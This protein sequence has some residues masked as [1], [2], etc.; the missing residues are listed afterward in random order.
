MDTKGKFRSKL[1]ARGKRVLG[2]VLALAMLATM[3]VVSQVGTRAVT[4]TYMSTTAAPTITF[5]APEAAWLAM[6]GATTGT[7]NSIQYWASISGGTGVSATGALTFSVSGATLTSCTITNDKIAGSWSNT[8]LSLGSGLAVPAQTHNTSVLSEWKA[9]FKLQGSNQTYIAYAYTVLWCPSLLIAATAADVQTWAAGPSTTYAACGAFGML[10]LH[11]VGTGSQASGGHGTH[12]NRYPT[13]SFRDAL[14]N[15]AVAFNNTPVDPLYVKTG[16]DTLNPVNSVSYVSD[17]QTSAGHAG[18]ARPSNTNATNKTTVDTSRFSNL[19]AVPGMR[20]A[21]VITSDRASTSGGS[22]NFTLGSS[23]DSGTSEADEFKWHSATGPNVTFTTGLGN[24]TVNGSAYYQNKLALSTNDIICALS[25]NVMKVNKNTVLRPAVRAGYTDVYAKDWIDNNDGTSGFQQSMQKVAMWLGDPKDDNYDTGFNYAG[26]TT[27]TQ[28][29]NNHSAEVRLLLQ[30]SE[31][32]LMSTQPGTP[33]GLVDEDSIYFK[34][35]ESIH[36]GAPT[37]P[38]Y[39]LVAVDTNTSRGATVT[40]HTYVQDYKYATLDEPYWDFY[41][42]PIVKYNINYVFDSMTNENALVTGTKPGPDN[43]CTEQ[44]PPT[45]AMFPLGGASTFQLPGYTFAGWQCT[46]K[47]GTMTVP[48]G[49]S[50]AYFLTHNASAFGGDDFPPAT[51]TTNAVITMHAMWTKVD[52]YRVN[53][54]NTT[55]PANTVTSTYQVSA[56]AYAV[57]DTV[58]LGDLP[59][60]FTAAGYTQTGW[61]KSAGG[62]ALGSLTFPANPTAGYS[63]DT[64]GSL[65]LFPVWQTAT[66]TV[67]FMK[68]DNTTVFATSTP[69]YS[70]GA[71]YGTLPELPQTEKPGYHFLGWNTAANAT[72][73]NIT[74]TTVVGTVAGTV[75]L[76][77]AWAPWEFTVQYNLNGGGGT[78]PAPFSVVYDSTTPTA[79]ASTGFSRDGYDFKGWA[80]TSSAAVS[81]VGSITYPADPPPMQ[82]TSASLR[83]LTSPPAGN[84]LSTEAITLYAVWEAKAL[85]VTYDVNWPAAA[86]ID[87]PAPALPG[88]AKINVK[89]GST[90]GLDQ[91]GLGRDMAWSGGVSVGGWVFMGWYQDIAGTAPASASSPV[92]QV[93]DH[94]IYAK[95]APPGSVIETVNFLPNGGSLPGYGLDVAASV[96]VLNGDLIPFNPTWLPQKTGYTFGGWAFTV[97][98]DTPARATLDTTAKVSLKIDNGTTDHTPIVMEAV[99]VPTEYTV[100]YHADNPAA[101]ALGLAEGVWAAAPAGFTGSGASTSLSGVK[102]VSP[103][104]PGATDVPAPTGANA[105]VCYGYNFLGFAAKVNGALVTAPL[106]IPGTAPTATLAALI[107]ATVNY[108]TNDEENPVV[109]DLFAVWEPKGGNEGNPGGEPFDPDGPN[110]FDPPAPPDGPADIDPDDPNNADDGI[111]ALYFVTGAMEDGFFTEYVAD[112]AGVTMDPLMR[113]RSCRFAGTYGWAGRLPMAYTATQ[114]TAGWQIVAIGSRDATSLFHPDTTSDETLDGQLGINDTL[115]PGTLVLSEKSVWVKPIW[116]DDWVVNY[117]AQG[118]TVGGAATARKYAYPG[119]TYGASGMVDPIRTDYDFLGW[120]TA[121]SGGTRV[122]SDED[123]TADIT[124]YAQWTYSRSW[125]DDVTNWFNNKYGTTGR[126]TPNWVFTKDLPQCL[127][128]GLGI[129]LPFLGALGFRI[130][131]IS[132]WHRSTLVFWGLMGLMFVPLALLFSCVWTVIRPI[133]P[134]WWPQWTWH[135]FGI[136]IWLWF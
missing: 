34:L 104:T 120:F 69:P 117:D 52:T 42:R 45:T 35:G 131:K 44:N 25:F 101:A 11:S 55:P 38:N 29:R 73:A 31:D 30:G 47:A 28:T 77:P 4:S 125:W 6:P 67:N 48:G 102:A 85:E 111:I 112:A 134:S 106:V 89:Y 96:T 118:G 3:L 9:E 26:T 46:T 123:V 132:T 62:A 100:V 81:I 61:S 64:D 84:N 129:S 21:F 12:S 114:Y 136:G 115:E 56:K 23:S 105:P 63:F 122:S 14:I 22:W 13:D 76:Y 110:P 59:P 88:A 75:T 93:D 98:A 36:V 108:K 70:L 60:Y 50:I 135:P 127:K 86:L 54:Y 92:T 82:A 8:N 10:G 74:A 20:A 7:S 19:N 51:G 15:K 119:Q 83:S 109:L 124:L 5:T 126:D 87:A 33:S 68:A 1:H 72:A 24:Q 39:E 90:Y 79:L 32:V 53:C 43:N 17:W 57:G 80:L 2:A 116:A 65:K 95:W 78:V 107:G 49:T 18:D 103:V 113:A 71:I 94:V 91:A 41:Y 99:W 37:I 97:A 40:D 133:M 66:I 58:N 16:A 121:P 128:T 130:A 27:P